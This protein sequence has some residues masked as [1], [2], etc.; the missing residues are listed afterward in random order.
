MATKLFVLSHKNI[1]SE[2]F[3]FSKLISYYRSFDTAIKLFLLRIGQ[4]C[5]RIFRQVMTLRL[6]AFWSLCHERKLGKFPFN[7]S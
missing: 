4:N 3:G 6:N 1:F 7:P 5:E 2:L